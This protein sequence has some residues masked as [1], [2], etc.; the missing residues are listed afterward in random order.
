MD[1]SALIPKTALNAFFS[2]SLLILIAALLLAMLLTV[3]VKRFSERL[4]KKLDD[5][6]GENDDND[7]R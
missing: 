2:N 4:E 7:R 3:G 5:E 1:I 6:D